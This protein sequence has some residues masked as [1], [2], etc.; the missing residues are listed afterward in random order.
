MVAAAE[1]TTIDESLHI[2]EHGKHR[3]QKNAQGRGRCGEGGEGDST[4]GT[5]HPK[6]PI[7]VLPWRISRFTAGWASC[8]QGILPLYADDPH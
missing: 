7:N 8:R 6:A 1:S 4:V 2:N 3:E 5:S